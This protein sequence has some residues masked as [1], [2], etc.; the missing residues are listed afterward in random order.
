MVPP[1]I[2]APVAKVA[3]F[4]QMVKFLKAVDEDVRFAY[5][6]YDNSF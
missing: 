3:D 2:F 4:V 6:L 1:A 5:D